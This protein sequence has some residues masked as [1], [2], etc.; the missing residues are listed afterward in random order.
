MKKILIAC[1]YATNKGDRAIAE[2][3]IY[4]LKKQPDVQIVL[5]TNQPELWENIRDERTRVIGLGYRDRSVTMKHGLACRVVRKLT[6]KYHHRRVYPDMMR[7]DSD[8]KLLRKRSRAFIEQV[9]SADLVIIT[10]G[11][12]ITS[13]R[14]GNALFDVTYDIGL[15]SLYAKRYVLWSQTI[16]PLK[17]TNPAAKD[18]FGRVLKGAEAIYIRDENS[19]T[20]LQELYPGLTNVRK[21]Y[22]SVFGFGELEKLPYAQR[23]RKVG[24]SIFNGLPKA[25]QTFDAI[26]VLLDSFAEK[27]Y[28]VEFFRME[29]GDKEFQDI[30][31]ITEKMRHKKWVKVFPFG[32]ST[33]EHLKEM[34]TCSC[35]IGYKTHSVIMALTT[36]TPLLGI[37]YHPKTRDFMADFGLA[38]YA[39]DD[40]ALTAEIGI[41]MA[42]NIEANAEQIHTVMAKRAEEMAAQMAAD[43]FAMLQE[44]G[45]DSAGEGK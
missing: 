21:S 17:F 28:A 4:Q 24:I 38:E 34:S 23:E 44:G 27:G 15:I 13:I 5:S 1:Q 42:E 11:H 22:D 8:H 43:L 26:A 45:A 39:V 33:L 10:G 19:R 16:G 9:Q 20:C 36:A 40:V 35:Y 14:A 31:N 37:C 7:L 2:Y 30:C 6:A 12:H 32:T 18:F 25:Y 3:L 41:I 29:H